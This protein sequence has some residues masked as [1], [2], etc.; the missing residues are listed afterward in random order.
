WQRAMLVGAL[1]GAIVWLLVLSQVNYLAGDQPRRIATSGAAK[2]EA[3]PFAI[4]RSATV[5]VCFSYFLLMAAPQVGMTSFLGATLGRLFQ[6]PLEAVAAALT[7]YL[8]G[9]GFGTLMGGFLADW[10]KHHER[11]V[12]LGVAC[13]TIAFFAI[14]LYHF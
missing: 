4:F 13:G 10:T 3:S 11:V 6:T 1:A 5:F 2:A 14:G 7:L 8:T 9:S 12:V